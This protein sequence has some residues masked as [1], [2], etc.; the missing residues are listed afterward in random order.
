MFLP[1][2]LPETGKS[3]VTIEGWLPFSPRASPRNGFLVGTGGGK[4]HQF[5][6]D[7][8]GVETVN[9]KRR[10]PDKRREDYLGKF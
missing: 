1:S 9:I 3:D 10:K 8:D 2:T 7:D 5:I 6:P 4:Q